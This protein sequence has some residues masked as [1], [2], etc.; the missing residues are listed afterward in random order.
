MKFVNLIFFITLISACKT[1]AKKDQNDEQP[2]RL[3]TKR[4]YPIIDTAEI[5]KIVLYVADTSI[6]DPSRKELP[7]LANIGNAGSI[8]DS[9]GKPVISP[10]QG[11]GIIKQAKDSLIRIFN[12]Y[13][14]S[15][16]DSLL[17]TNCATFYTHVFILYD[18]GGKI[19]EQ[20]HMCLDC[21]K[22]NFI[23]RGAYLEF[24][25]EQKDLFQGL[26]TSIRN[27]DAFVPEGL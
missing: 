16:Q 12:H 22:L 19:R 24:I 15:P 2:V 8:V 1:S 4:Q 20:I 18:K 6:I 26:I 13:L 27:L 11:L 14:Q 9:S 10:S 23:Y 7:L 3:L 17:T 5:E 25:D 21:S